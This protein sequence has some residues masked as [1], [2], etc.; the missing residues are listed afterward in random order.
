MLRFRLNRHESPSAA[1]NSFHQAIAITRW[2]AFGHIAA[3]I[4]FA[5]AD[6]DTF[7][8]QYETLSS[9]ARELNVSPAT[10][11]GTFGAVA[12]YPAMEDHLAFGRLALAVKKHIAA[13]ATESTLRRFYDQNS[14][15]YRKPDDIVG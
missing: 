5:H 10:P 9:W 13:T 2:F 8:L 7:Q 14:E 15:K 3:A 11:P 1:M 6:D 4:L 12:A